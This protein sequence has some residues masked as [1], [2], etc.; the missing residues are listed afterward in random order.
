MQIYWIED[1]Q[2]RGPIAVP[3]IIA[4][5]QM[6]EIDPETTLGWHNGCE[7]WI[8]LKELPALADFITDM[9][10]KS[11]QKEEA[12]ATPED[13]IDKLLTP[14]EPDKT[15]PD[16]V[17]VPV[18]VLTTPTFSERMIARLTDYAIYAAIFMSICYLFKVPYNQHLLCTDPLFWLPTILIESYLLARFGATPGKNLMG[19]TVRSLL[20][21]NKPSMG[22]TLSRSI[23]VFIMGMGCFFPLISVVMM[24]IAYNMINKGSLTLWDTRARTIALKLPGKRPSKP[25]CIF[26][27]IVSYFIVNFCMIPWLPDIINQLISLYPKMAEYLKQLYPEYF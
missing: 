20:D 3:D 18:A 25:L 11:K 9:C 1:K 22:C 21:G 16:K 24:I 26:I 23:G 14:A 4:R 12:Q 19:I 15:T 10:N 27:I 13:E 6:G 2:K 8:P 7:K 17:P 5:I